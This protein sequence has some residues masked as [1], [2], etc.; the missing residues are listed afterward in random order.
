MEAHGFA[1]EV[2]GVAVE[3]EA[4]YQKEGLALAEVDHDWEAQVVGSAFVEEAVD[5]PLMGASV[6]EVDHHARALVVQVGDSACVAELDDVI[7]SVEEASGFASAEAFVDQ[8]AQAPFR[9]LFQVL[10]AYL[11]V[12][13]LS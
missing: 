7:A 11:A 4:C 8:E 3:E 9:E 6:E 2:Q 10:G 13:R 1:L 12:S 5:V